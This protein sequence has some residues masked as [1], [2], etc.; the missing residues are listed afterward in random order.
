RT[1]DTGF[2][3]L[4][5]GGEPKMLVM[6]ARLYGPPAKAK[7]AD[8][9]LLTVQSFYE[10]P[11]YYTTTGD[12]HELKRVTDVNPKAREFNWGKAELVHY[13]SADGVPLCGMLIKPENFDPNKKYPMMVYIYERLSQNVHRFVPPTVGTSINAT[14]YASNGY[15]VFMPDIAYKVGS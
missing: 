14:F 13:H 11:D 3:R 8:V 12:F 6:G 1:R 4:N 10:P 2:F 15:L 7:S 5:P 9:Y